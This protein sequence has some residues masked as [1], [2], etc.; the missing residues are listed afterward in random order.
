MYFSIALLYNM[1]Y[2]NAGGRYMIIENYSTVRQNLKAF[3][4]KVVEEDED[5]IITRKEHSD[6]VMMSLERYS[7]IMQLEELLKLA[8]KNS[9]TE[10]RKD[11]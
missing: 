8:Q 4:D 7:K 6:V 5:L 1:L 2:N 11:G 10:S 3:C 9:I